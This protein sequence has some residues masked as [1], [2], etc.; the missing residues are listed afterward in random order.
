[1]YHPHNGVQ[2]V[3]ALT[4]ISHRDKINK[5]RITKHSKL[6]T[7]IPALMADD[8]CEITLNFTKRSSGTSHAGATKAYCK[9]GRNSSANVNR[10]SFDQLLTSLTHAFLECQEWKE[11]S[12]LARA[13]SGEGIV[14]HSVSKYA[15]QRSEIPRF[16]WI[17]CLSSAQTEHNL[18]FWICY[19]NNCCV[20]F[21]TTCIL[22]N[23]K[24]ICVIYFNTRIS[25]VFQPK[26][27]FS[28]LLPLSSS[29]TCINSAQNDATQEIKI[30][31]RWK[32]RRTSF[33][34]QNTQA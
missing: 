26:T 2:C 19:N 24:E 15:N 27:I 31:S 6:H 1:M 4:K 32:G 10:Q 22:T 11:L 13:W 12:C 29:P 21:S 17:P 18:I 7:Q 33:L 28:S 25:R 3:P 9:H 16:D 23:D 34:P 5:S 14:A 20:T 30:K 8:A